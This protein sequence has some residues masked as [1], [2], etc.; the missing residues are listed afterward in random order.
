MKKLEDAVRSKNDADK[1]SD[2][3][4]SRLQMVQVDNK[5]LRGEI[6]E[7]HRYV[8]DSKLLVTLH[9]AML[10]VRSSCRAKRLSLRSR[11]PYPF[12]K[13]IENKIKKEH[14]S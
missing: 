5:A 8:R 10:L 14:G 9:Y 2:A 11:L 4:S 12:M 13:L 6:E 7:L 3:I 1:R